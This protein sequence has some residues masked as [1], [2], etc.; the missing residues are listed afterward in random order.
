VGSGWQNFS[1]VFS[2]GDGIIYGMKSTG[3]MLWYQHDGYLD[4]TSRWQVP[5]QVASEWNVFGNV[6]PL[7]WGSPASPIVR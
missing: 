6:F 1:K 7:M 3:E 4:G 2:P 5:A